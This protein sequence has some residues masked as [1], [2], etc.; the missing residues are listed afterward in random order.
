MQI[1]ATKAS[2]RVVTAAIPVWR[3][4]KV[5]RPVGGYRAGLSIGVGMGWG[6]TPI[7]TGHQ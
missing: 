3:R 5:T 4:K 7:S 2:S 1:D 6:L